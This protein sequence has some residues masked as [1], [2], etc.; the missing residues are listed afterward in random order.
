RFQKLR[1]RG[2]SAIANDLINVGVWIVRRRRQT[3][4]AYARAF[5]YSQVPRENSKGTVT[6]ALFLSR[7]LSGRSYFFHRHRLFLSGA[8]ASPTTP[9]TTKGRRNRHHPGQS[10]SAP[11]RYPLL[12]SNTPRRRLQR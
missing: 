2:R 3:P 6:Y 12:H 8:G 1:G 11:G 7:R 4:S 9:A 10:P 5:G